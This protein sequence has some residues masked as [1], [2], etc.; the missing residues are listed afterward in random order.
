MTR[1][2]MISYKKTMLITLLAALMV[3]IACFAHA[4][5]AWGETVD[6]T[7]PTQAVVIESARTAKVPAAIP[8]PIE[9]SATGNSFV[10]PIS[11]TTATQA[12]NTANHGT[13]IPQTS[14]GLW[15]A[16]ITLLIVIAF[17]SAAGAVVILR[18]WRRSQQSAPITTSSS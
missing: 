10:V 6:T 13:V 11:T 3:A 18:Q 14:N 15:L 2:P 9:T 5:T 1:T 8:V 12:T 7:T 17:G 4:Q 16:A